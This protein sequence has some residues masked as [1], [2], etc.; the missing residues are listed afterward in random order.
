MP[1][2]FETDSRVYSGDFTEPVA[3]SPRKYI[4]PIMNRPE[5]GRAFEQDYMV[6]FDCYE[7]LAISTPDV[8]LPDYY[9]TAETPL[10]RV[11]NGIGKFTRSFYQ[12]ALPW[13]KYETYS[14]SVPGI[15]GPEGV[16]LRR[17]YSAVNIGSITR[18]TC[19]DTEDW[20]PGE[21]VVVSYSARSDAEG[22]IYGRQ[23]NRT[24][25]A[26][27]STTIVDVD[28]ITDTYRIVSWN[29][30]RTNDYD[31]PPRQVVVSSTLVIECFLPGV[32][33]GIDDPS[34][35]EILQPTYI[36][37]A[38][39]GA[40]TDSYSAT[41]VPTLAEYRAQVASKTLIIAEPSQLH[42]IAPGLWERATRYVEAM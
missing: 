28:V 2:I 13:K 9:L 5:L 29:S 26:V 4:F 39:T 20:D 3:V 19:S 38:A 15:D 32:S 21:A 10:E 33:L 41:T 25:V 35:I 22:L 24:I 16:K 1:N 42:E 30:I 34:D 14:Y 18:I 12:I 36:F 23:V 11:G 7:P 40:W 31:R 8:D 17:I 27:Q 6:R 37:E